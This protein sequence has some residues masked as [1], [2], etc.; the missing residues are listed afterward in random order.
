MVLFFQC[1]FGVN[2]SLLL[3]DRFGQRVE[4]DA[5]EFINAIPIGWRLVSDTEPTAGWQESILERKCFAFHDLQRPNRAGGTRGIPGASV[6]LETRGI[7]DGTL[8]VWLRDGTFQVPV[9]RSE[10]IRPSK[11]VTIRQNSLR[12]APDWNWLYGDHCRE[13]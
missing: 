5:L 8:A 12:I 2:L 11:F 3:S 9:G 13:A 6:W 1:S 7:G 10:L 4:I